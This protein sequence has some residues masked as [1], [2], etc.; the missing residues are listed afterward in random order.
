MGVLYSLVSFL[1]ALGILIT[2]HEFG[3]FWMARRMGVKVLRFSIGFGKPLWTTRRGADQTEYVVAALPLGGYVKMLDEREAEV[4]AEERHRA[5]NRQGVA[6]RIAIVCAGPLFNFLLAIGL[7]WL[8]FVVGLPGIKPIVNEV[9]PD[10]I[11]AQAGMRPGDV[12]YAVGER[13]TPTLETLRL[14]LLEAMMDRADVTL[15]VGAPDEQMRTITADLSRVD[16]DKIDNAVLQ[17][18]GFKPAQPVIPPIV[19]RVDAGGAAER[20]G[21]AP[22]D[23]VVEVDG[24]TVDDWI[25]LV[26]YIQRHP[27]VEVVLSVERQGARY[28]IN[29]VPAPV[30]AGKDMIGRIGAEPEIPSD[31]PEDLKAKQQ[32]GVLAAIPAA[33]TKTWDMSVLTLQ[34]L[35][36]MLVGEASLENLSGPISIAQIAGQTAK[37]GL[38]PFLS[39]LAIVSISLGVLNLLPIPVLDG[40]HLMYYLAE[41]IKG[42]PISEQAQL[43]GQKI[44]LALLLA[45]MVLAFYNDIVRLF[46]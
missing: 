35:W 14:A 38:L 9:K 10:S 39:F 33:L 24:E 13:D 28:Q 29:V 20:A 5:F 31:I 1:V 45:L 11:M 19:R 44:G 26:L 21:L 36:K 46:G 41:M 17:Y 6:K 40:G 42:S 22:G 43:V 15:T 12:I 30:K 37:V 8:I 23:R 34:M 27:G 4:A 3:H 2:A 7:Y 32:Y 16:M 25:T 18:L